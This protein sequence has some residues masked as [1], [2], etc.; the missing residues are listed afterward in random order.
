MP[1]EPLTAPA[2]RFSPGGINL[3]RFRFHPG[4]QRRAKIEG[5]LR[6]IIHQL[7]DALF[8]V[9]NARDRVWSV[10]LRRDFFVPV[11]IGISGILQFDSLQGRIFPRRL[12]KM[13]VDAEVARAHFE[14]PPMRSQTANECGAKVN[15]AGVVP[16]ASNF[17]GREVP[18]PSQLTS[19]ESIRFS[20]QPRGTVNSKSAGSSPKWKAAAI[21]RDL[22]SNSNITA[23]ADSNSPTEYCARLNSSSRR[24][25][26]SV[27]YK[28]RSVRC[29]S[30]C[31]SA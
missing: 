14:P 11:M 15:L 13:A 6:V 24:K 19:A 27:W 9:E 21:E 10:A 29:G 20:Q 4:K 25:R 22:P 18:A 3:W 1:G 5:H 31:T 16:A 26:N 23:R 2:I 17:A 28:R 8:V 7:H 12:I 30:S